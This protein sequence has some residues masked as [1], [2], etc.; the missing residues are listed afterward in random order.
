MAVERHGRRL[1]KTVRKRLTPKEITAVNNAL[2]NPKAHLSDGTERTPRRL[3]SRQLEI[4]KMVKDSNYMQLV[5]AEIIADLSKRRGMS[6]RALLPYLGAIETLRKRKVFKA[7]GRALLLYGAIN[8]N[9]LAKVDKVMLDARNGPID[10]IEI[11]R[12]AGLAKNFE[13]GGGKRRDASAA[14]SRALTILEQRERVE[15]HPE[16]H[17]VS[18][19][20]YTWLHSS[21]RSTANSVPVR[22]KGFNVM[23]ELHSGPKYVSDLMGVRYGERGVPVK[24]PDPTATLS[25]LISSGLASQT[26]VKRGARTFMQYQLTAKGHSLA[27]R[28]LRSDVILEELRRGLLGLPIKGPTPYEERRYHELV[29][30]IKEDGEIKRL[31]QA[32]HTRPSE[33]ARMLG[34]TVSQLNHR[35]RDSYTPLQ[36]MQSERAKW[37]LALMQRRHPQYADLFRQR[38]KQRK[39]LISLQKV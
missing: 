9:L 29:G 4:L 17:S 18:G 12:R 36:G 7:D 16:N 19:N 27:S 38:L 30:W 28:Q 21:Y 39:L 10:T 3:I 8:G 15:R 31:K 13:A 5:P 20:P 23:L 32:G 25:N 33:M 34:T 6:K 14:V 1:K 24:M 22:N 2:G 11:A 26:R 37:Y 35:M